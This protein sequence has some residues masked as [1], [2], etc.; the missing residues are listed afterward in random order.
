[1]FDDA[2][3]TRLDVLEEEIDIF[4]E[5]IASVD[6]VADVDVNADDDPEVEPTAH[7]LILHVPPQI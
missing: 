6:E 4:E 3:D 2:E 1:V 7:T 5:E